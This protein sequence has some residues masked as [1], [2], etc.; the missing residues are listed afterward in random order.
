VGQ[1]DWLPGHAARLRELSHF[2]LMGSSRRLTVGDHD[3][4]GDREPGQLALTGRVVAVGNWASPLPVMSSATEPAPLPL[5]PNIWPSWGG[6]VILTLPQVKLR[7]VQL[8]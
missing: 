4:G 2:W 7:R 6:N 1:A 3:F 8:A 5:W